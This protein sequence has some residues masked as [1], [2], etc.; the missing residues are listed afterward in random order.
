MRGIV[1]NS[2]T[3]IPTTIPSGLLA[4][5]NLSFCIALLALGPVNPL[6]KI[7]AY[8]SPLSLHP[9]LWALGQFLDHL[10]V[11]GM[12]FGPHCDHLD[13]YTPAHSGHQTM[14]NVFV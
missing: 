1:G 7:H 14:E 3:H 6:F 2:A 13:S 11:L 9:C 5:L 8:R 12:L 10:T 4:L